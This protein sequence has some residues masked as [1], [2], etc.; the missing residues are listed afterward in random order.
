MPHNHSVG[1]PKTKTNRPV[2]IRP[3]EAT[4]QVLDCLRSTKNVDMTTFIESAIHEKAA[5][6]YPDC[7]P[8]DESVSGS[9]PERSPSTSNS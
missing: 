1:R 9:L 6:D 2:Q 3:T 7:L 5:R 4:R 8:S